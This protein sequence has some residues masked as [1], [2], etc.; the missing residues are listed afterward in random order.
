MPHIHDLIDFTI[1]AYIYHGDKVLL[2]KHKKYGGKWLAVGGH[3]ELD[4]DSDQALL[5]EIEEESGLLARDISILS[6]KPASGVIGDP[7]KV[8]A[9]YPPAFMDIHFTNVEGTHRHLNLIYFVQSRSN[10]VTLTDEHE[11]L[12]WF[13]EEELEAAA[14]GL[15]PGVKYYASVGFARIKSLPESIT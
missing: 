12:R 9:L 8:K 11:A 5:R 15:T 13:G 14:F 3:I 7:V 4:E 6:S 1:A 10:A 2:V